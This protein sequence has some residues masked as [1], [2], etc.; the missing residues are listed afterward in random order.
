MSRRKSIRV[1]SILPEKD[2]NDIS[3]LKCGINTCLLNSFYQCDY[4]KSYICL[5]HGKKIHNGKIICLNCILDNK[6]I[7]DISCAI[8]I[9]NIKK[10]NWKDKI[11]YIISLQWIYCKQKK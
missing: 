8:K 5:Q 2:I 11:K 1:T 10:N 4:C 9:N 7:Y 6:P 3:I